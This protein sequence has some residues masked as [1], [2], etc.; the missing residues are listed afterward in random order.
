MF[1]E[2]LEVA[3]ATDR[4]LPIWDPLVRVLHWALL[5]AV[6][7]AAATGFF[8]DA[9]S[10]TLHVGAGLAACALVLVRVLWGFSGPTYARFASFVP[11]PATLVAYVRELRRQNQP[12]YL[13]HNPLGAVMVLALLAMIAVLTLTGL[14]TLGGVLKSGPLAF[15]TSFA[16]GW[17]AR[18]LHELAAF[19]LLGLVTLHLAGV[20]V[21]SRRHGENL[22]RAMMTGRKQAAQDAVT[23]T[24]RRAHGTLALA[25]VLGLGTAATG[26]W[27]ALATRSGLGVPRSAMDPLYVSECGAC[28]VAYHPSLLPR[29][30]WAGL[31]ASLADHFGEDASL[32]PATTAALAAWL[33]ANAAEA[34]D[35]KAANRLRLVNPEPPFAITATPF[36]RRTHHEIPDAVFNRAP[37]DGRGNCAACHRDAAQGTF[38]PFAIVIPHPETV[39]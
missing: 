9:T 20:V 24:P 35:T 6:G 32:D 3:P 28:H 17:S 37:I 15:A 39:P 14:V 19:L 31:M 11:A 4:R 12:R 23:P 8:G 22:V 29:T 7:V 18:E 5:T 2:A 26:G 25:L 30:A 38:R 27:F 10:R 16:T 33:D 34:F 21:E 1:D 36:W 13:G